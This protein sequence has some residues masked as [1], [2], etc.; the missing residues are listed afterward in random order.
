MCRYQ[1]KKYEKK[2]KKVAYNK[3]L[4]GVEKLLLQLSMKISKSPRRNYHL[5]HQ[6]YIALSQFSKLLFSTL[7]IYSPHGSSTKG[8][9]VLEVFYQKILHNNSMHWFELGLNLQLYINMKTHSSTWATR[10]TTCA[11]FDWTAQCLKSTFRHCL[12][13]HTHLDNVPHSPYCQKISS[14]YTAKNDTLG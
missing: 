1:G 12:L 2:K 7:F 6:S 4:G 3:S 14:V 10:K 8:R 13:H 5:L 9:K 11:S